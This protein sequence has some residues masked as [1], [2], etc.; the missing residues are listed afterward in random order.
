MTV[1]KLSAN[2]LS[3]SLECKAVNSSAVPTGTN[4]AAT[5]PVTMIKAPPGNLAGGSLEQGAR[6]PPLMAE[7]RD[8]VNPVETRP[9]AC[10]SPA[11]WTSE[12]DEILEHCVRYGMTNWS[13]ISQCI[14]GKSDEQCQ[15]RWAKSGGL[16]ATPRS[17]LGPP[18]REVVGSPHSDVTSVSGSSSCA[19]DADVDSASVNSI[20]GEKR[21]KGRW[22]EEED[23]ILID[24]QAKFGNQW[25]RISKL[26][27]GRSENAVKNRFKS[28]Y[29]QRL[30]QQNVAAAAAAA[31]AANGVV[32][33]TQPQPIGSQRAYT[34]TAS[35]A[36]VAISATTSARATPVGQPSPVQQVVTQMGNGSRVTIVGKAVA[37]EQA[38]QPLVTSSNAAAHSGSTAPGSKAPVLHTSQNSTGLPENSSTDP[39]GSKKRTPSLVDQAKRA[40][41]A[42][43]RP[44]RSK[45]AVAAREAARA[46]E[47]ERDAEAAHSLLPAGSSV[48]L[49]GS[50]ADLARRSYALGYARG[51]S[52]ARPQKKGG[53]DGQHQYLS[54]GTLGR[55]SASTRPSDPWSDGVQWDFCDP[56]ET[57]VDGGCLSGSLERALYERGADI[58]F[59]SVISDALH[60]QGSDE[61]AGI[62][63]SSD[64]CT[65]Y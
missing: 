61:L 42:R 29:I 46:L 51:T 12:Q 7:D 27:P 60:E 26:L 50:E 8:A 21:Q 63:L 44:S 53:N 37:P 30:V 3:A 20:S 15:Q 14:P 10:D 13:D 36:A 31:T 59:Y 35:G 19:G 11:G 49:T 58:E 1:A 64:P 6:T 33:P 28:A 25:T 56:D 9:V 57:S 23:H 34:G 52:K 40:K 16:P 55:H 62:C 4:P 22:G 45:A 48:P 2:A 18:P 65:H 5:A 38:P 43:T 17:S 47:R 54:G 24:S 32:L 39:S 41:R